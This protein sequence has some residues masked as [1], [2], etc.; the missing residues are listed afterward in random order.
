MFAED[1]YEWPSLVGMDGDKAKAL[2]EMYYPG[3]YDI[4]VIPDDA[5]VTFGFDV[6]RIRI[7]VNA[8]TNI[9][10]KTPKVG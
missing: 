6:Y 9:V 5:S 1:A 10:T 3:W 8:D 2:L 4:F 7:F